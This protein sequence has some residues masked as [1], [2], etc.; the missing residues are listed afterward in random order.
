MTNNLI[1]DKISLNG[2]DSN[3]ESTGTS[4]VLFELKLQLHGQVS[5]PYLF[6]PKENYSSYS[7]L[8]ESYNYD[9]VYGPIPDEN[10]F[11]DLTDYASLYITDYE[12]VTSI[13]EENQKYLDSGILPTNMTRAFY[14]LLAC[15][16]IDISNINTAYCTS[17]YNMFGCSDKDTLV[18]NEIIGL[19]N[20]NVQRLENVYYMFQD[21]LCDIDI[22]GWNT[23]SLKSTNKM[24]YA[25]KGSNINISGMNTSN[26][27]DMS[28]MFAHATS[29]LT[30]NLTNID[31]SN[32]VN[33]NYMFSGESGAWKTGMQLTNIIG[34]SNLNVNNVKNM[35]CMFESCGN[36]ITLDLQKWNV[37]NV[38][39]MAYM[40]M[41]NA[42]NEPSSKYMNIMLGEWN[43]SNVTDMSYMFGFSV[44]DKTTRQVSGIL[45]LSSCTTFKN[46]MYGAGNFGPIYL[47]N[48]P[49]TSQL[50]DWKETDTLESYIGSSNNWESI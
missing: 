18:L 41:N 43:T 31:T 2:T 30:I 14:G 42:E 12:T 6:N 39:D 44:G 50:V 45:D 49:E 35:S 4:S 37:S 5:N 11:V 40:F 13:P 25:Y 38:T 34:L 7:T 22:S 26:V 19:K 27:T 24:F 28:Y 8:K 9:G 46:M 47:K 32:V 15:T 3:Y 23:V 21:V 10:G 16:K 20:K 29:L 48:I 17:M 1:K 33:M 36:T